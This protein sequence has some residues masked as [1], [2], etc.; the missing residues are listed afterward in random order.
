MYIYIYIH[1]PNHGHFLVNMTINP[2]HC[3]D[4][5]YFSGIG[6]VSAVILVGLPSSSKD[7]KQLLDFVSRCVR[8]ACPHRW[9]VILS[10]FV[11]LK[12]S[13]GLLLLNGKPE[14]FLVPTFLQNLLVCTMLYRIH[15]HTVSLFSKDKIFYQMAK[16]N[17]D[18]VSSLKMVSFNL[19][20]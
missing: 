18:H 1:I 7:A 17:E 11:P 8:T 9:D 12:S 10:Y 20:L 13:T 3:W 19:L 15:P 6:G 4:V 16:F 14:R 5:S 2:N